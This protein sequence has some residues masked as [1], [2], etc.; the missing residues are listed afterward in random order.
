MIDI[1]EANPEDV[2]DFELP[3]VIIG[4]DVSALYPSLDAEKVSELVYLAVLK[5]NIKWSNV[6]YL[7]ASRYIAMNWDAPTCRKSIL[8]RV[9]PVRRRTN[10]SRPGVRGAGPSGPLR[11]D[12]EQWVF[13]NVKLTKTEK[14]EII[15]TVIRIMTNTMF[16]THVYSFGGKMYKQAA[17]GPIGLRATCAVA[18]LVMKIWDEK[19]LGKLKDLM[20]KIEEATRYMDDG[21]T[22]M[23]SFKH[24]W[25]W[26]SD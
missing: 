2:Q 5:S 12:T 11:G 17:G 7:E 26:T 24:G 8:R 21:R 13:R 25:R 10:G 1:K 19:W 23:Y 18:R 9:L 22:A 16:D 3:M 15:A 4:S 6:D 14:N 20:V